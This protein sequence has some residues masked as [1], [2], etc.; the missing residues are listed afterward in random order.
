MYKR[1]TLLPP[2]YPLSTV[3]V[4]E[5]SCGKEKGEI[6]DYAVRMKRFRSEKKWVLCSGREKVKDDNIISLARMVA[7]HAIILHLFYLSPDQR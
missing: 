5:V 2:G 6:K 1:R 3:S 4:Q 7:S